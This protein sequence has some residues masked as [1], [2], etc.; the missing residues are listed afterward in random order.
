MATNSKLPLIFWLSLS[1]II[2]GIYALMALQR[3][4]SAFY[5]VQDDA[6]QHVFWMQRFLDPDLL[7][8]DLIA[9]Y[10]QSVAPAGYTAL[11]K[12]LAWAGINPLLGSKLL[13]LVLGLIM[14]V[15]GFGVCMQLL[16][17]PLAGF[18]ATILLN[19]CLWMQDGLISATPKAFV[20]PLLMPVLYYWLRKQLM[21]FS[22]AL[23]LLGLFYPQGVLICAGVFALQFAMQLASQLL[24]RQKGRQNRQN[25]QNH[26]NRRDNL[27]CAT[28][29][30]VAF[31]VLL[32]YALTASDFGPTI[33]A[34]QAKQ[35]PEFL[36]GGRTEFF[37]EDPWRFWF[38]SRG[39][40][41]LSLEPPLMA[42]GL[43]LPIL[44]RLS[45]RF[46]RDFP[47]RFPL[48]QEVSGSIRLLWQLLLSSL[49]LFFAAH[50]LLFKLHLP[51]RYTQHSLRIVVAIAAG[52][53]LTLILDAILF[54]DW[55]GE[56]TK[57]ADLAG[58][59]RFGKKQ[60]GR[61]P[62]ALALFAL[63]IFYPIS[64]KRFPWTGY[65]AGNAPSLYQFLQQQPK[66]SLIASLSE[67]AN[68]LPAFAQRS[69]LVGREYAIPYHLGYYNELRQRTIALIKAQ[70]SSDLADARELIGKYGIDFWLIDRGAF[71]A[72]YIAANRWLSQYRAAEEAIANLSGGSQP[73]LA[74]LVER[75]SVFQ[76]DRFFLLQADCI[77][78]G[79]RALGIGHWALGIGQKSGQRS[80]VSGQ[81]SAN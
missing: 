36:P 26:Q 7:P 60:I 47:R 12:L 45:R 61:S 37:L 53:A 40:I 8:N 62:I 14:T 67:E 71:S 57:Q 43:L 34:A 15:Y 80:A 30:G 78:N 59:R 28:G 54:P 22:M 58:R 63:L 51:S 74:T 64:L 18:V 46:R 50:A 4:L 72:E 21:A 56:K 6:R 10:F 20:Y 31:L 65:I 76:S 9:D 1:L 13:P 19:Q 79:N 70:Y 44:L 69:I 38:S 35:W 68:N 66:D 55:Q 27:L 49:T 52:I 5:L 2:A 81:R 73:A 16:P 32:P 23:I 17:V 11:Y 42:F 3:G 77:N 25:H 29:L 33:A 75:C 41:R 24:Q 39:G 48:A